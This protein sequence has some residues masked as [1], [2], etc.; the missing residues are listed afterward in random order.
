MKKI[1]FR[2]LKAYTSLAKTKSTQVDVAA[3][4]ADVIYMMQGGMAAHALAHKIYDSKGEEEYTDEE[5]KIIAQAS[6][7]FT[8]PCVIDAINE[9]ITDKT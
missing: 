2:T 4:L 8:L 3:P 9:A 1:N 7:S 6:Q 5:C